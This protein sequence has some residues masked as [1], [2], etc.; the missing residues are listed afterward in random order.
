MADIRLQ[1]QTDWETD[2]EKQTDNERPT[3]RYKEIADK[4]IDREICR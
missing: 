3:D 4:E 2:R 1:R